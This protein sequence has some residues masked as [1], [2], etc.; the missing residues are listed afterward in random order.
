[1]F[2]SDI[3]NQTQMRSG[4]F[5]NFANRRPKGKNFYLLFSKICEVKFITIGHFSQAWAESV[6]P[7]Q[8]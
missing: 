1:M 6:A 4:G 7:V 2:I 3:E 8:M 5:D